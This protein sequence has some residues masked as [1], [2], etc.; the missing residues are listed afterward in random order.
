MSGGAA[1]ERSARAST[2]P[3][4]R[5]FVLVR[6]RGA[7][8]ASR[9]SNPNARARRALPPILK[10]AKSRARVAP[11]I[12]RR[13]SLG[14]WLIGERA[15]GIDRFSRT[16][17]LFPQRRCEAR[18]RS[19]V[20]RERG[21]TDSLSYLVIEE[22]DMSPAPESFFPS[23]RAVESSREIWI[24]VRDVYLGQSDCGDCAERKKKNM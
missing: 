16:P 24:V 7:F 1:R 22:I 10:Y 9:A 6:I 21:R 14:R 15:V 11:R 3:E 13:R 17:L 2:L 18:S 23:S 20:R 8:F 4:T 19:Y 5:A 12:Q